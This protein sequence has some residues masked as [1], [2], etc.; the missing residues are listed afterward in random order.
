MAKAKSKK[1][2]IEDINI[3]QRHVQ[4]TY[5]ITDRYLYEC[6]DINRDGTVDIKDLIMLNKYINDP[7][8]QPKPEWD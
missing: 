6:A 4:K 8:N 3:L 2:T 1:I 5:S 7:E